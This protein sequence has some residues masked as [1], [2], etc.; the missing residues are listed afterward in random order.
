MQNNPLYKQVTIDYNRINALP[1]DGPLTVES[2]DFDESSADKLECDMRT[3]G[4]QVIR[5]TV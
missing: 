3:P 4:V 2:I 5:G 1:S